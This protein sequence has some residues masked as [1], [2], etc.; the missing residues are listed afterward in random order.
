M[1]MPAWVLCLGIFSELIACYFVLFAFATWL[2][3][4]LLYA[5][6][7]CIYGTLFII[8]WNNQ[9]IIMLSEDYFEY[10]NIW[11]KKKIYNFHDIK[12][13][14]VLLGSFSL[15][16]STGKVNIDSCAVINKRLSDKIDAI[17]EI[18]DLGLEP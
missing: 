17:L 18:I 12:R 16:T 4:V 3:E 1:Y 14:R 6:I 2:W 8:F 9:K 15:V 5:V 7:P 10:T 11:G 13:Y